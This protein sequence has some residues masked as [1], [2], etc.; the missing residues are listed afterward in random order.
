MIIII[1]DVIKAFSK[2]CLVDVCLIR[3]WLGPENGYMNFRIFG[4]VATLP[5]NGMMLADMTLVL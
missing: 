2:S 3:T 1:D 5:L 4:F